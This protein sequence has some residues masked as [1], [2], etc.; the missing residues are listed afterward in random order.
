MPPLPGS[1]PGPE[2]TLGDHEARI[3]ALE[4]RRIPPVVV[5]GRVIRYLI[6]N[7]ADPEELHDF[8][9]GGDTID[10]VAGL[11]IRFDQWASND[12]GSVFSNDGAGGLQLGSYVSGN[13]DLL[14]VG[15]YDVFTYTFWTGKG[16]GPERFGIVSSVDAGMPII[17]Y[18]PRIGT[19]RFWY[20]FSQTS[21]VDPAGGFDF[22]VQDD[23]VVYADVAN[24]YSAQAVLRDDA[25]S[26]GDGLNTF[27]NPQIGLIW[28]GVLPE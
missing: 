11:N 4:R 8:D 14:A 2:R 23:V 1:R 17:S 12:D 16:T 24:A 19:P 10:G 6:G 27:Y 13:V 26:G 28:H 9:Q 18:D 20:N 21:V 7:M 5:P 25:V 15:R 22:A 3:R